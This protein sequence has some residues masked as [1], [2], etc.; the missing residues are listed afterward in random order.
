[1]VNVVGQERMSYT[2]LLRILRKNRQNE[3]KSQKS[4]WN[5][6]LIILVEKYFQIQ[7]IENFKWLKHSPGTKLIKVTL[8]KV[9]LHPPKAI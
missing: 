7:S 9:V 8:L 6:V 3:E 4:E 1:M 5:Y 2:V